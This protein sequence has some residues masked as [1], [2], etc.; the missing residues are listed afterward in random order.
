MAC[1]RCPSCPLCPGA[2]GSASAALPERVVGLN[3]ADST[4]SQVVPGAILL[5][6]QRQ[7]AAAAV[8]E[9]EA[10]VA[11]APSPAMMTVPGAV[12]GIVNTK[13]EPVSVP[14]AAPLVDEVVPGAA[15]A[16][17]DEEEEEHEEEDITATVLGVILPM[18]VVF[19]LSAIANIALIQMIWPAKIA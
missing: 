2:P 18:T 19:A 14:A 9:E 8:V 11:P 6:L 10:H 16:A 15:F 4:L 13:S 17:M 5:P 12:S 3:R 1:P 7:Q